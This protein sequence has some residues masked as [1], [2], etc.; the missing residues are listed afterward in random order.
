MVGR[1]VKAL[2]SKLTDIIS[3]KQL[4]NRKLVT[5]GL[6]T[7]VKITGDLNHTGYGLFFDNLL[8]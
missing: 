7:Y 6:M 1:R 3:G 5:Q 8:I 4:K 2:S